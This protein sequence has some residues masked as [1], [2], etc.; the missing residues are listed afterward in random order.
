MLYSLATNIYSDLNVFNVAKGFRAGSGG[1]KF[2][3][4]VEKCEANKEHSKTWMMTSW[5]A[6]RTSHRI[7]N[8][9]KSVSVINKYQIPTFLFT[10]G[11]LL[12][13]TQT[14]ALKLH[15]SESR[16]GRFSCAVWQITPA[17]LTVV[18]LALVAIE[19]TTKPAKA[20]VAAV[21]LLISIL[22]YYGKIPEKASWVLNKVIPLPMAG[23]AFYA[24][25]P[26]TKTLIATEQI[27]NYAIP[28]IMDCVLALNKVVLY[29]HACA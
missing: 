23:I 16:F 28:K 2:Y 25:G 3:H 19:I 29:K 9:G 13:N 18:N 14:W 21:V 5:S 22:D 6:L 17:L 10:A 1:V 12:L 20:T 7:W 27:G 15:E 24:G 4:F 8:V 26:I 11:L